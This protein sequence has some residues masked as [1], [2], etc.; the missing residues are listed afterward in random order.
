MVTLEIFREGLEEPENFYIIR[1][2]IDV[3][4]VNFEMKD[5]IAYI[6]LVHFSSS[7]LSEFNETVQ[8]VLVNN[9]KGIVLDLRNNP[10]GYL[11]MAIEV[12]SE[13]IEDGPIVIET[14]REGKI[15]EFNARG[16]ARLAAYKTVVL[17]NTL[18]ASGSEI[19]AGALQDYKKATILGEQTFGKGSVQDIELLEDGS[20]I[21]ITIAK[22]LTP[23]SRSISEEGIAPDVEVE[24]TMD[25]FDNN[26]DPQLDKAMEV[27]NSETGEQ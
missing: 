26:R 7:T 15:D 14:G 27:L 16:E 8:S 23:H 12:A 18:S 2:K 3:K 4:S 24:L 1:N 6:E 25:D 13:W 17:V 9:P 19:V 21:K 22:W 10:G 11:D 5:D 20:A